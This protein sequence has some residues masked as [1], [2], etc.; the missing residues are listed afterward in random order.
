[1]ETVYSEKTKRR[2]LLLDIG[3]TNV[4]WRVGAERGTLPFPEASRDDGVRYEVPTEAIWKAVSV[5]IAQSMADRIFLS[6]QMHGYVLLKGGKEVTAYI[7]WRDRRRMSEAENFFLPK[8]SGTSVKPNLPRLS[9]RAQKVD[10]DCFC[11]LGSYLSYRLTGRNITHITDA[12][13]SGFYNIRTRTAEKC[14]FLLPEVAYDICEV[15]SFFGRTVYVPVGDQQASAAGACGVSEDTGEYI[16]NLGTAA[17]MCAIENGFVA[18]DYESRPYF[19]NR[20][21]CMVSGLSGGAVLNELCEEDAEEKLLKDCFD[22]VSKL[23]E[24]RRI[25]AVGG[26]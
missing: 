1:M 4:K 24:K 9:I 10:F 18:G 17:Q 2:T 14:K 8:E 19:S 16:W 15:G 22:A 12:A 3:S 7:S 26:S 5:L 6:V 13:A 21:I 25:A 20:T 23:P 11:T